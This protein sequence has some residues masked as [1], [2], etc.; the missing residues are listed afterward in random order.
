MSRYQPTILRPGKS[1]RACSMGFHTCD[2][3]YQARVYSKTEVR[4]CLCGQKDH[5]GEPGT[6][7]AFVSDDWKDYRCGRPAKGTAKVAHGTKV[8]EVEMCGIHLRALRVRKEN[9]AKREAEW[10]ERQEQRRREG[11]ASRASAEW[12]ERLTEEFGIKFDSLSGASTG[13]RIRVG[14]G[15]EPIYGLLTEVKALLDEVYGDDHPLARK[16]NLDQ[17]EG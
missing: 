10:Q 7:S 3:T 14:I 17:T 15:P 2:G 11:E 4:E 5:I 12:A 16:N 6:C 13:G 1:C 8:Y 9:D